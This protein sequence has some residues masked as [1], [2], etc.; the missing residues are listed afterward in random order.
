MLRYRKMVSRKL[1][2]TLSEAWLKLR[3]PAIRTVARQGEQVISFSLWG[4]QPK[5][6]QG[7]LENITLQK[8]HYPDWICR[9]YVSEDVPESF[10][11]AIRNSGAQIITKPES[12]G[13]K[14]LYWRFEAAWD[15]TVSRFI[16][17][18]ADS[19]L[20]AREAAAVSEWVLSCLPFHTMR[21]NPS[22]GIPILGGL[23][24]AI[25]GFMPDFQKQLSKWI[26]RIE[27]GEHYRGQFFF[28]DQDFLTAKIWPRVRHCHLAHT[29][30]EKFSGSDR[31]FTV[32]LPDNRF[33]GQQFDEHNNPILL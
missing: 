6:L 2:G 18:D 14:G 22:H 25:G 27:A 24:G 4:K 7:A 1:R 28:T 5:Y 10:T 13:F 19:R 26:S 17:R 33:I 29:S 3:Y 9:F 31:P 8:K 16:V 20:N 15:P 11:A 21:D 12:E 23:W 32:S 30:S